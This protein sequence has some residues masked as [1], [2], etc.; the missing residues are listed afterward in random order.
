MSK[1]IAYFSYTKN[2]KV[3]NVR[4]LS[5]NAPVSYLWHFG[6]GQ[7]SVDKNATNIY[8]N[9][10]FYQVSLIA[11]NADG[12]SD[13]LVMQ[14]GIGNTNETLNLPLLELVNQYIPDSVLGYSTTNEKVNLIQKWQLYLQPAIFKPFRVSST[15]TNN[16]F[17]WPLLANQLIAMLVAHDLTVIL[18]SRAMNSILTGSINTVDESG[19]IITDDNIKRITTGPTEV[20]YQ[21]SSDQSLNSAKAIKDILSGNS[22]ALAS[23][24]LSLC[25]I[26]SKLG[27]YIQG[28]CE[29]LPNMVIPFRVASNYQVYRINVS[30]IYYAQIYESDLERL[31][32]DLDAASSIVSDSELRQFYEDIFDADYYFKGFDYLNDTWKIIRINKADLTIST[33]ARN[34]QNPSLNFENAWV[35]RRTINYINL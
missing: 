28:I 5:L 12:V 33:I 4:D 10:G 21:D 29:K 16:E 26:A 14:I 11:T 24:R 2:G 18:A 1:P 19:N 3:L 9:N 20:E 32:A 27:I 30:G 22:G 23:L 7:T 31:F 34:A 13:P 25:N 17:A 15:D 8:V 6:D 35:T